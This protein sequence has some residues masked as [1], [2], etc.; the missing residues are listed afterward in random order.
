MVLVALNFENF[1]LKKFPF[2]NLQ[3]S[4]VFKELIFDFKLKYNQLISKSQAKKYFFQKLCPLYPRPKETWFYGAGEK[5]MNT[6]FQMPIRTVN[7]YIKERLTVK[8]DFEISSKG[9]LEFGGKRLCLK[10]CRITQD[11]LACTK[12][13]FDKLNNFKLHLNQLYIDDFDSLLLC[14]IFKDHTL[15]YIIGKEELKKY[16][17]SFQ[18]RKENCYQCDIDLKNHLNKEIKF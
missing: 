5:L 3:F 18:H 11:N 13:E 10:V 16:K 17:L 1:T 12:E 9:I 7:T 2:K 8:H 4:G 6:I 15:Y 14:L